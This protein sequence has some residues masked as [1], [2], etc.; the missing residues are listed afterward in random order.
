MDLSSVAYRLFS[1]QSL[2]LVLRLYA[3]LL[4]MVMTSADPVEALGRLNLSYSGS[5]A[6]D[7]D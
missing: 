4:K 6:I 5:T 1:E 2:I 3:G 7:S